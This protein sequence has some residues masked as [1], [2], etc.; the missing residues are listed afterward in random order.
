[1]RRLRI[2]GL[3]AVCLTTTGCRLP[4][5]YFARNTHEP[6]LYD[7]A[8]GRQESEIQLTSAQ[9]EVRDRYRDT[10]AEPVAVVDWEQGVSTTWQILYATNRARTLNQQPHGTAYGNSVTGDVEYGYCEVSLRER[11]RGEDPQSESQPTPSWSQRIAGWLGTTP[12]P[13]ATVESASP[14]NATLDKVQPLDHE[15][16]FHY[17]RH[18]VARS[19]QHD[20]LV[21]VHGFNVSYEE[22]VLRATQVAA[23]MPFNGAIVVYSW[24]S[25]G[26]ID[27][28]ERDGEIVDES[29][30]PFVEF[31]TQ[32]GERL[33]P[34][35]DIN[36]LVHS[37][38]NRLVTRALWHLPDE[39]ASPPRF[40]EIV[41]CAPDV[42]V[43][44]FRRNMRRAVDVADRVTLYKNCNDSAL[45]AS[46]W[47]HME[48]R[49]GECFNPI[50]IEGMDSIE[51]AV[52]DTSLLG[53]S[54]YGSNTSILR[55][56]FAI[57]KEHR[58]AED[59]E[60]LDRKTIP[61]QETPWWIITEFPREIEWT[62]HFDD[63]HEWKTP[64]EVVP[65]AD[66][67]SAE[68]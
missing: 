35:T 33:P 5:L 11:E 10:L 68:G 2:W 47:K 54:Y 1:M 13:E 20:V 60:W 55:D 3:I 43:D 59:R 63:L 31:L 61:F 39:F 65:G 50:L 34:E 18:L 41:L 26:G 45:I 30:E 67:S 8:L 37:M 64:P 15:V 51:T 23:D 42:G 66:A 32:L 17:L 38:G 6:I 44:E 52:V 48:E 57:I 12:E 62:W 40:R 29:R 46:K 9:V 21:F 19:R 24:P 7:T 58:P 25:Q 56:M 49:A 4:K 28:Y 16:F 53:H 36:L 27:N 22:A 14:A